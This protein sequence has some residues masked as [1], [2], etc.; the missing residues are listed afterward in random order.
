MSGRKALPSQKRTTDVRPIPPEQTEAL[1]NAIL[2]SGSPCKQRDA[3]LV[4]LVSYAGLRPEEALALRWEDVSAGSI[5]VAHA[6]ANG[7]IGRTKTE[8]PRTVP[9]IP[10]LADD[11]HGWCK[12]L[13]AQQASERHRKATG[14]PKAN[15]LVI[16]QPDGSPW[17]TAAY[18]NWRARVFK[19]HLPA[20]AHPTPRRSG[21][22][23]TPA[24]SAPSSSSA[25]TPTRLSAL[26][27]SSGFSGMTTIWPSRN[28][29]SRRG[30]RPSMSGTGSPSDSARR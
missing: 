20:D 7:V 17:M 10:T 4:S 29:W 12:L 24:E 23:P 3:M 5:R 14:K 2:A 16:A 22:S 25:T 15:A 11:L 18:G 21:T 13:T 1:R 6:N 27:S 8:T 19:K 30:T 9:L 28:W 26:R